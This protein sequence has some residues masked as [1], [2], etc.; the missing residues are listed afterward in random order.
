[1]S[2]KARQDGKSGNWQP[3]GSGGYNAFNTYQKSY[4]EGRQSKRMEDLQKENQRN[5]DTRMQEISESNRPAITGGT[6]RLAWA[7]IILIFYGTFVFSFEFESA[8]YTI[9][10]SIAWIVR[11][12]VD[13]LRSIF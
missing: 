11:H 3:P 2:V 7:L 4:D 6:S 10:S 1:M 5:F 12:F 9:V 8:N 13:W